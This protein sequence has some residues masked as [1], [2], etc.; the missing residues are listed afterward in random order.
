MKWIASNRYLIATKGAGR[1]LVPLEMLAVP[2]RV[3]KDRRAA[4]LLA[5][6]QSGSSQNYQ[7]LTVEEADT[8][9]ELRRRR[10]NLRSTSV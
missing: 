4:L 8:S 2:F 9:Y 1:G 5:S 3:M 10:S 6:K 7:S